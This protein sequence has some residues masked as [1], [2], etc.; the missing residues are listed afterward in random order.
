MLVKEGIF[1]TMTYHDRDVCVVEWQSLLRFLM[2][3]C[4]DA[5]IRYPTCL[6]ARGAFR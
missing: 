4:H 5:A 2:F 3:R 1:G 6:D